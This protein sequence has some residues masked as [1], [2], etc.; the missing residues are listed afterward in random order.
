MILIYRGSPPPIAYRD[1]SYPDRLL[2]PI[3]DPVLL[4]AFSGFVYP[5]DRGVELSLVSFLPF[6]RPASRI[7]L[8]LYKPCS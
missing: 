1:L 5:L 3:G 2:S 8:Y 7:S 4:G 6:F